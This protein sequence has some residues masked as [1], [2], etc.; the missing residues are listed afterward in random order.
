MDHRICSG[1]I[2]VAGKRAIKMLIFAYLT[3]GPGKVQEW[4]KIY[5]IS[6]DEGIKRRGNSTESTE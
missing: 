5:V 2:G 4:H 1:I 6:S 3:P